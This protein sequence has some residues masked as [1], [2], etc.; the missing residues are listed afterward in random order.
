MVAYLY[1]YVSD[2]R[3]ETL[4]HVGAKRNASTS[5]KRT[6]PTIGEGEA[7]ASV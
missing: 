2:N 5:G 6:L 3:E 4:R 7:D 1:D